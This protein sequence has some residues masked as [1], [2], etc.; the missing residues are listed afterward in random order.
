MR[1]DFK[2]FYR[3]VVGEALAHAGLTGA[4]YAVMGWLVLEYSG[5]PDEL[6]RRCL[7]DHPNSAPT[8]YLDAV[9][10]LVTRGFAWVLDAERIQ[11]MR[12]EAERNDIPRVDWMPDNCF[13][14]GDV[15]LTET[16]YLTYRD[17]DFKIAGGIAVDSLESGWVDDER[18][19]VNVYA[20]GDSWGM[21]C[22]V[23]E[24]VRRLSDEEKRILGVQAATRVGRWRPNR[25]V[26]HPS[27]MCVRIDY[28]SVR[29]AG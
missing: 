1:D 7:R 15:D 3:M 22:R 6:A 18:G 14:L 16:G 28:G 8:P 5:T 10:S 9:N 13:Q 11:A 24:V 23:G 12:A 4:E 20:P 17:A 26:T 2:Q 27:G 25:F 21:V 29:P 19:T